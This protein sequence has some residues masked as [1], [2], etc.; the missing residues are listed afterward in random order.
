MSSTCRRSRL[1]LIMRSEFGRSISS[2]NIVMKVEKTQLT[3]LHSWKYADWMVVKIFDLQRNITIESWIDESGGDMGRKTETAKR[4]LAF[5]ARGDVLRDRH[6]LVCRTKDEFIW[7][8]NETVIV[9]G[10]TNILQIM[11]RAIHGVDLTTTEISYDA[12]GECDVVTAWLKLGLIEWHNHMP[13]NTKIFNF[14]IIE[15]RPSDLSSSEF[16][17]WTMRSRDVACDSFQRTL[18]HWIA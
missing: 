1:M 2:I 9:H 15:H 12:L 8:E 13:G 17:Y 6:S 7:I 11:E 4:R 3:D 18:S 5:E 14:G 16:H 10:E